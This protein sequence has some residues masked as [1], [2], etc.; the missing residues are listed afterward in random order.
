M[1]WV[2]NDSGLQVGWSLESIFIVGILNKAPA[3]NH[4]FTAFYFEEVTNK[5]PK[6]SIV[7]HIWGITIPMG[8]STT[9]HISIL[10]LFIIFDTF[11]CHTIQNRNASA[12]FRCAI[13]YSLGIF[14]LSTWCMVFSG[15][16]WKATV[17][18]PGP[19]HVVWTDILCVSK[20]YVLVDLL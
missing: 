1:G 20:I 17:T 8:Y 18:V 16:Q 4:A 10:P 13:Q 5:R 6:V 15:W 7:S 9:Q 12:Q 3:W 2:W 11:T 19:N 14:L